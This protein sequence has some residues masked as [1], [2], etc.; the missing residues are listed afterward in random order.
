VVFNA[1]PKTSTGQS[2]KEVLLCGQKRLPNLQFIQLRSRLPKYVSMA[3][4]KQMYRQILISPD[5][6]D[7]LRIL[8]R[9]DVSEQVTTYHLCTYGTSCAPHQAIRTLRELAERK[10]EEYPNSADIIMKDM[11]VYDV[12]AGAETEENAVSIQF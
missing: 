9:F 3:D 7:Y 11:Y 2:L 1:S 8:W 6:R 4:I 12:L 10:M 5:D